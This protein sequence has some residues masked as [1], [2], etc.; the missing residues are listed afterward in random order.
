MPQ[1]ISLSPQ[2]I[3]HLQQQQILRQAHAQQIAAQQTNQYH[4]QQEVITPAA[5]NEIMAYAQRYYQ[6]QKNSIASQNPNV[7]I[8][9]ELDK[10]LRARA[11]NA[12]RQHYIQALRRQQ[13][14][15]A[16]AAQQGGM[17]PHVGM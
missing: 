5:Q 8:S 1:Q 12:A 2:Q 16:Q 3:H 7:I 13:F 17:P 15:V 14:V 11:Q 9:E 6:V 10:Q 4:H